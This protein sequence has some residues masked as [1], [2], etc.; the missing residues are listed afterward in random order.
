[1]AFD[2]TQEERT[3]YNI[4]RLIAIVQ[5]MDE[6][7]LLICCQKLRQNQAKVLPG[8]IGGAFLREVEAAAKI[9]KEPRSDLWTDLSHDADCLFRLLRKY[10]SLDENAWRALLPRLECLQSKSLD[11]GLGK[12]FILTLKEKT[13]NERQLEKIAAWLMEEDA[14]QKKKTNG[15]RRRFLPAQLQKTAVF[16][17]ACLSACFLTI[18]LYGQIKRNNSNLDLQRMKTLAAQESAFEEMKGKE[19]ESDEAE[20]WSYAQN[21]SAH[22][23]KQNGRHPKK[24]PQYREMS[25]KYPEIYG[26]LKIPDTQIDFPVMKSGLEREEGF[27]L[28]HNFTGEDSAEGAL[29]VDEKSSAYPQDSNTVIYGH[30]MKNGHMFGSLLFY[31]DA[32]YLKAHSKIYFDT[33]YETGEYEAVAVLKT[34]LLNE[35]EPGFR[36]YRFFHYENKKEFQQCQRFIE[37]NRL[38]ETGSK[39]QYGDKILMLSTCEYSQENGRLVVVARKL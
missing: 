4:K 28:D 8:R 37:Q 3:L 22:K 18:W 25:E 21:K 12:A 32:D 19:L 14:G 29:F 20:L 6:R 7:A 10:K 17:F 35:T 1:M 11:S 5:D 23:I 36:Y 31:T 9:K 34:R 2:W 38:F 24:L 39:L 16:V 26:W 30:N 13:E 27:Y 15:I 33:L